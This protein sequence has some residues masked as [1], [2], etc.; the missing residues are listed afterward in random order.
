MGLNEHLTQHFARAGIALEIA[1][2][3]FVRSVR[4][5]AQITQIDIGRGAGGERI[6]CF[7]SPG[8]ELR[9]LGVDAD[10]Q[11]VVLSVR[12]PERRFVENVYFRRERIFRDVER[13]TPAE[14]R[15]L[16]IG[17]DERHLFV[18]QLSGGDKPTSVRD[19]HRKLAP[20]G[21]P[22][23]AKRRKKAGIKRQG[24][25]FFVPLRAHE[26]QRVVEAAET[27]VERKVALGSRNG[28]RNDRGRP[29]VVQ[30]RVRLLSPDDPLRGEFARGWVRHPEH[31]T[32]VLKA[33]VRVLTNT[34]DRSVGATWVD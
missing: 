16:L 33:W 14:E 20:A 4:G 1:E 2:R 18:A 19:A 30:E 26:R 32:I 17:M 15:R 25:W 31:K 22:G 6:R 13:V 21:I 12:E 9:V 28:R 3:G 7:P 5:R 11:Q 24:E 23:D 8:A 34:E 27:L 29:H 10:E